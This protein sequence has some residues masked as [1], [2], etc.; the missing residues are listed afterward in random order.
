MDVEAQLHHRE[1]SV[2]AEKGLSAMRGDLR[3]GGRCELRLRRRGGQGKGRKTG[4][5]GPKGREARN[6]VEWAG[7]HTHGHRGVQ[8]WEVWLGRASGVLVKWLLRGGWNREG[9]SPSR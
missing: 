1:A 4:D 7:S 2:T 3:S 5:C 6:I 9:R 8:R